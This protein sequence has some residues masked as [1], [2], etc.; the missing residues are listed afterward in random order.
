MNFSIDDGVLT[1]G[2]KTVFSHNKQTP[3]IILND[4]EY[5]YK[6]WRGSL[7]VDTKV[8]NVFPLTNLEYKKNNGKFTLKFSNNE[9]FANFELI[10]KDKT[11]KIVPIAYSKGFSVQ[12]NFSSLANEQ[13]FGLGE[14]FL[15]L[16]LKGEIVE[17]IV[18]EHT[19][20]APILAKAYPFLQKL[21]LKA[22]AE[23]AD[24]KTYCPI[25]VF[26][27][28]K[29]YTLYVDSADYGV[30]DFSQDN[31]TSI[32][33]EQMP[34]AISY[35]TGKDY[36]QLSSGLQKVLTSRQYL[37]DWVH[38][39][40]ILGIKGSL[41]D[42]I[43]KALSAK[44]SGIAVAGIWCENWSGY[45]QTI[46]GRQVYW[47]WEYDNNLYAD[48][49]AKIKELEKEGIAFL[50]YNNP[51]LLKDAPMY[52][53]FAE[54]GYLIKNKKG[55]VYHIKTTTF[56]AGM[57]DLSNP[58]AFEYTKNMIIQNYINIGI[59][60]WM[61]DF[62]EYLPH[63][64]LLHTGDAKQL[65]NS[66]PVLWARCNRQ[67][68]E[69]SGRDDIFF[70]SR[71]GYAGIADCS[72]ILWNGDQHTDYSADYGMASVLPATLSL[73][74]SGVPLCHSDIAG[75]I[76]FGKLARDKALWIK[77]L[78][79]SAFSPLMRSH[80]TPR[81]DANVQFDF[82]D[83]IIAQTA[84]FS[85]IHKLLTP[86][87]QH[88]ITNEASIGIPA[89]RP[90]FYSYPEQN[91]LFN[92]ESCYMLGADLFVAPSFSTDTRVRQL[93]LPKDDWICLF[94][95]L[96]VDKCTFSADKIAVLYRKDSQF[97]NTFKT[98]TKYINTFK[99]DN[100]G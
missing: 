31:L 24:I 49:P 90:V 32:T 99:G 85:N 81:P 36:A 92:I 20:L 83:E 23:F 17:N 40:M 68:I 80:A 50:A 38:N 8:K 11:L 19:S 16:N 93:T 22:K 73:A 3:F 57:I 14:R 87:L 25:P 12:F 53:D 98:I 72:P 4:C 6:S 66:W 27:S 84:L 10:H 63:D 88:I 77:W 44:A 45:K 29:L 76:T 37:P 42:A 89:I 21:G 94:T 33:F 67:A 43:T 56:Q 47:N 82:D 74:M 18:S 52:K 15:K 58:D 13:I 2:G 46:A 26:T 60:G 96:E 35:I 64:C 55:E 7:K 62:G 9:L 95:G 86:Y 61:A 1:F 51:Y 79:M 5:K 71:S 91:E 70:F 97:S 100:D 75:F 39:G 59:K 48:L 78:Q 41:D 30:F 34:N 28:S 54:K 69:Q 65:H